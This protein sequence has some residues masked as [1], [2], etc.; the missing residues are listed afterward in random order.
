MPYVA[1][2]QMAR[3]VV[4]DRSRKTL[5]MP[6]QSSH[7]IKSAQ[8]ASYSEP[9]EVGVRICFGDGIIDDAVG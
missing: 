8:K 6:S 3:V 4:L 2:R 9:R 5:L 7:G 1:E